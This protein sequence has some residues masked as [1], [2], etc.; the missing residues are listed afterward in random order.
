MNIN[1]KIYNDE[2]AARRHLEKR[3]WP[4]GPI[5]PHCGVVN[6]ATK[7]RGKSTRKGVYWCNACQKPFSV[8]VGTA[9]ERSHIPLTKWLLAAELMKDAKKSMTTLQL[10]RALGVTYKTA[11]LMAQRI[12][13]T[14]KDSDAHPLGGEGQIVEP[15]ETHRDNVA[16]R[17]KDKKDNSPRRVPRSKAERRTAAIKQILDAGEE[18]FSIRGY[19]GVT[20]KDVAAKIGVHSALVL[21]YFGDKQGLFDAV[22]E[23]RIIEAT[24]ARTKA[25]DEYEARVGNDVTVEGV[26]EAYYGSAFEDFIEGGEGMLN[27][28]RLF[29][30]VNNAPGYGTEKMQMSFHPVV[31][32]LIGLLQKALPSVDRKDIFWG[33]QFTSGAYAQSMARTGRIDR[34][35]DGLCSS[36]DL[37]AVRERMPAFMAAGF[38]ALCNRKGRGLPPRG[39]NKHRGRR[40]TKIPGQ[41]E[42]LPT[43]GLA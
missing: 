9:F 32:R 33:F 10:Q 3:Q 30:L 41:A 17:A 13:G 37:D 15:D 8:T 21:Y 20:I 27:F 43:K 28:G 16:R 26:L 5:C 18:L 1:S 34:L 24:N 4:D 12:R 7:L 14:M 22:W 6:E 38:E 2:D 19:P 42:R 39:R 25:L 40:R 29:A 31:M 11:W 23:R 35:S 36:D